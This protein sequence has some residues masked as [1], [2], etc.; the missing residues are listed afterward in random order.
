[1]S[2]FVKLSR[3]AAEQYVRTQEVL[4]VP[5]ALPA[6][7]LKQRACYVSIFENPGRRLRSM[8]GYALPQHRSLAHEIIMNTIAALTAHATRPVRRADL[9][10]LTYSVGLL[11]PLQ[12]I[13]DASHLDPA[14][15]GL[16]VRADSGKMALLLPH[17]VGIETGQ[18]QIG[19]AMREG[20]ISP[21]RDIYT[22][23][24]FPVT[25]YDE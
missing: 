21:H 25:F 23:Y 20:A 19:A 1:M 17:R 10:Y 5:Q 16:Y 2:I 13:S 11:G 24:R 15:F 4:E 22:M 14:Q 12:R 7:L 3:S 9:S 6:E 8:Y 18:D